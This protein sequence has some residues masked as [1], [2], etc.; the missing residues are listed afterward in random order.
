[1]A[2]RSTVFSAVEIVID[3]NVKTLYQASCAQALLHDN[4]MAAVKVQR[5][6]NYRS[7]H[8]RA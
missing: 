1:M 3:A 2:G 8:K 5:L 4:L 6:I 7:G